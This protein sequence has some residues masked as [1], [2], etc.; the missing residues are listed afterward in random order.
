[1]DSNNFTIQY[2]IEF[3]SNKGSHNEQPLF[4][5]SENNA[6]TGGKY[7][8]VYRRRKDRTEGIAGDLVLEI[9]D[10]N[11]ISSV[12][13]SAEIFA[14][15]LKNGISAAY[16]TFGTTANANA[17]TSASTVLYTISTVMINDSSLN[18]VIFD[19]NIIFGDMTITADSFGYN[20]LNFIGTGYRPYNGESDRNSATSSTVTGGQTALYL[21]NRNEGAPDRG[22]AWNQG[23]IDLDSTSSN[24]QVVF[25]RGGYS[26]DLS[27]SGSLTG[28]AVTGSSYSPQPSMLANNDNP[29][30]W[31]AGPIEG[32]FRFNGGIMLQSVSSQLFNPIHKPTDISTAVV[33]ASSALT[34]MSWVN[35]SASSASASLI[36]SIGSTGNPSGSLDTTLLKISQTGASAHIIIGATAASL[37]HH[38]IDNQF[39]HRREK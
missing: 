30:G 33:R 39:H 19:G 13:G 16:P 3:L 6:V 1:M 4:V 26:I 25:D 35:V 37:M 36:A 38:M 31:S 27:A 11:G 5:L 20:D 18:T 32:A 21:F 24:A 2:Q 12:T 15:S 14:E 17:G 23:S 28:N 29:G 8:S 9:G 34:L 22:N 10:E 7:L